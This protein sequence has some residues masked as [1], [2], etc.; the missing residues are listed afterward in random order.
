MNPRPRISVIIPTR[1]RGDL[2][3]QSLESLAAQTLPTDQFEVVV[4]DDGS[5]DHTAQVCSEARRTVPITY[6]RIAP[7]GISAAKN[8][9]VFCSTAPIVFFFDDDDVADPD[10]LRQHVDTHEAHPSNAVAVLGRTTWAPTLVVSELMHYA[11]D[12]GKFLFDYTCITHGDVLDYTFFWGGRSSCK[13]MLLCREG[14]FDQ[15]FRF[16]SEDIELGY[17]LQRHGFKVVYNADALSY[18]NRTITYDE[19]CARCERQGR[20]QHH[21][22]NLLH[23]HDPEIRKYCDVDGAEE[24][25]AE[26]EPFL[27]GQMARV[28]ELELWLGGVQGASAGEARRAEWRSELYRLYGETFRAHKLKGLAAA[29]RG[30]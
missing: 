30:E 9:G 1:N 7:S 28:H 29:M 18:M 6:H 12:V 23:G 22:G 21:F 8:L 20:S 4:I 10:L 11:T 5:S 2:L 26:A 19:F 15:E 17:R 24:R 13:R 16:G 3:R 25:W 27:E 14:V